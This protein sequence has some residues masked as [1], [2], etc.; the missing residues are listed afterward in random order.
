[1]TILKIDEIINPNKQKLTPIKEKQ[2]IIILR[3]YK[4]ETPIGEN[5]IN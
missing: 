5:R 4:M 3:L 1:M 2:D